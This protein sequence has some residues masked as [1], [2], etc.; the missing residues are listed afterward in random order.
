LTGE[1]VTSTLNTEKARGTDYLIL[2]KAVPRSMT[3]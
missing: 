3:Y 2:M 1:L